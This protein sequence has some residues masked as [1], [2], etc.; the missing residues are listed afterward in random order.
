[1]KDEIIKYETAVLAKE[2]GFDIF[3]NSSNLFTTQYRIYHNNGEIGIGSPQWIRETDVKGD[4][5]ELYPTPT[6]SLLQKWLREIHNINVYCMPCEYDESLWYHNIAS[7]F[8]VFTGTYES[9]LEVGLFEGLK[10]IKNA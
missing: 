1:M 7:N 2:K 4:F 3:E 10:L 5:Y 9:A 6:Q 8:K